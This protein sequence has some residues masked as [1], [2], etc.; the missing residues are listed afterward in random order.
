MQPDQVRG[1]L[2]IS[3]DLEVEKN[4]PL[5]SKINWT[6][7][8]AKLDVNREVQEATQADVTAVAAYNLYHGHIR[9]AREQIGGRGILFDIHGQVCKRLSY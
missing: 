8:R 1:K 4:N 2:C 6:H 7:F 9:Q 3:V 5:L